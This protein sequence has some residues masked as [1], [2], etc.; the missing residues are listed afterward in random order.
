MHR[1]GW[2]IWRRLAKRALKNK[3]GTGRLKLA[4]VARNSSSQFLVDISNGVSRAYAG[5][6]R[7]LSWVLWDHIGVGGRVGVWAEFDQGF[8][9]ISASCRINLQSNVSKSLRFIH[10]SL[11]GVI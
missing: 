5:R 6:G 8:A 1:R 11:M 10:K 4:N 9:L 3:I 7:A 2:C